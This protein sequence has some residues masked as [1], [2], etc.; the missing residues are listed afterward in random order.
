MLI[1]KNKKLTLAFSSFILLSLAFFTQSGPIGW[2][3]AQAAHI[4]F[5]LNLFSVDTSSY[6]SFPTPFLT[7]R[8]SQSLLWSVPPRK[9][10][11]GALKCIGNL[12]KCAETVLGNIQSSSLTPLSNNNHNLHLSGSG[13]LTKYILTKIYLIMFKLHL[14]TIATIYKIYMLCHQQTFIGFIQHILKTHY[15]SFSPKEHFIPSSPIRSLLIPNP[16]RVPT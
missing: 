15:L 12:V 5:I 16:P 3:S 8:F 10:L 2:S 4:S 1:N 6:Y 14:I 11:T 9:S 13:N 7:I